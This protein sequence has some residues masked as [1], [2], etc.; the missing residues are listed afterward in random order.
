ME[1]RVWLFK[2]RWYDIDNNKSQRTHVELEYKAISMSHFWFTEEPIILA[3]QTHQLFY[4]DDPKNGTNWKVFQVVKNKRIWNMPE[5]ND[6]E[7]EQL[8][9]LKIV[10]SHWE[11]GHFENDIL[12]RP[13]VDPTV[14][15]RSVVYHLVNDFIDVGDE[16][17]PYQS[18]LSNDK[19]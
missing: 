13:D 19:W 3:T 7:N 11:N 16:Q 17:F 1:R 6:V 9:V 15:K 5:G 12:Y 4:L 14:V 8:N 10:V 18:G 2:C